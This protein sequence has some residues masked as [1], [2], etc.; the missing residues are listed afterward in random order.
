LKRGG[1]RSVGGFREIPAIPPASGAGKRLI[2]LYFGT[3]KRV[4]H[5][6]FQSQYE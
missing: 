3:K 5:L 1:R 4:N 2:Q 6:A